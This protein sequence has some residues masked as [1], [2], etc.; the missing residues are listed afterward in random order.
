[1]TPRSGGR[2][3]EVIHPSIHRCCAWWLG[4]LLFAVSALVGIFVTAGQG[5]FDYFFTMSLA[6]LCL[7]AGFIDLFRA[8]WRCSEVIE[9]GK[10]MCFNDPA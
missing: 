5:R 6:G 10:G 4:C 9:A 3:Q 2:T 8:L 1:M 7:L